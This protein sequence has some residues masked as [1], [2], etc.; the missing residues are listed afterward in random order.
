MLTDAEILYLIICVLGLLSAVLFTGAISTITRRCIGVIRSCICAAA[1]VIPPMM[2][3]YHIVFGQGSIYTGAPW[4][5][6]YEITVF[7]EIVFLRGLTT[8]LLREWPSRTLSGFGLVL[9]AMLPLRCCHLAYNWIALVTD[10][11]LLAV[12]GG[13]GVVRVVEHEKSK[14]AEIDEDAEDAE[15]SEDSERHLGAV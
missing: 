13:L 3:I 11:A 10:F 12:A 15:D 8:A 1:L 6:S 9:S 4:W 7:A 2:H 5:D 14:H